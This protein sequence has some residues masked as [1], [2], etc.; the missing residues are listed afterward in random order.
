MDYKNLE[1]ITV[2]SQKELDDIPEDFEGRIYIEF[3]TYLN[4]AVVN[5]R[6]CRSVIARENSS[7]VARG[8]SSVIAW[9]NSSVEAREN[10]SVIAWGNSSVEARE[11]S[12][13]VAWGNSSVEARENSSVVARGNT[14]VVDRQNSLG[15]ILISG[16]ARKVYMP[17]NIEEFM[18]FYEIEHTKTKAKFYKAVR[19]DEKGIYK[20]GWNKDFT[21]EIGKKKKE[22]C[23]DNINDDCSFGIH[24]SY[25]QWALDFG[26]GWKDLAILEVETKI[27]DIVMPINTDGKVR[28]SEIKV[29]REVPLEE[30]GLY[31]KILAKRRKK[32]G[33]N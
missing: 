17:K 10:S 11:N 2:K 7:V 26:R 8:N 25:L 22:K 18:N 32:D 3:G 6:Y 33:N 28:T 24:I 27:S 23:D 13:V 14:Q 12:S 21:Y 9:G 4:K 31:G 29:L 19:K 16:N 30:C 5:K 15:K 1:E 20:S